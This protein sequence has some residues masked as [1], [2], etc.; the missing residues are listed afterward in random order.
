MEP[1]SSHWCPVKGQEATGINFYRKHHLN[2]KKKFFTAT[3]CP[4][5]LQSLHPWKYS[6]SDWTRPLI[7]VL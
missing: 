3:S 7:N 5:H 2:L 6:N 1:D 4:E